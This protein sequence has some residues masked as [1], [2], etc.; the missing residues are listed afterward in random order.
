MRR[1]ESSYDSRKCVRGRLASFSIQPDRWPLASA[2]GRLGCNM[3]LFIAHAALKCW[4]YRGGCEQEK[5]CSSGRLCLSGDDGRVNL[6]VERGG[7]CDER[8]VLAGGPVTKTRL[9]GVWTVRPTVCCWIDSFV[10][11]VTGRRIH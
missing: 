3:S 10:R 4:N 9:N 2:A 11:G 5:Q 8:A 7:F 6:A 1:G